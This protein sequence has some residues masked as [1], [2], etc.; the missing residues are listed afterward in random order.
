MKNTTLLKKSALF[1]AI[2]T[3]SIAFTSCLKRQGG[4]QTEKGT[5]VEVQYTPELDAFGTGINT[6]GDVSYHNLHE[7][8]KYTVVFK[9]QHKTVFSISR[10]EIYAKVNKGDSV[11]IQYYNLVDDHGNVKDYD[12]IDVQPIKK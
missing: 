5:V 2:L 11:N 4:L 8:E 12:F 9:C 6:S 10:K 3:L 1:A 7:S